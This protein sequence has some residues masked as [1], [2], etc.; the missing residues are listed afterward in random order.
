[1]EL[2]DSRLRKKIFRNALRQRIS[3]RGDILYI[4]K[5]FQLVGQL[6]FCHRIVVRINQKHHIAP[7][8]LLG[9][10]LIIRINLSSRSTAHGAVSVLEVVHLLSHIGRR[11]NDDHGRQNQVADAVH[12][13]A[14][15]GKVREEG[16]VFRLI[17]PFGKF[18]DH[19]RHEQYHGQKA[20]D[21][22]LCQNQA[23]IETDVEFHGNQGQ[24]TNYG[25]QAA[26]ENG[27]DGLFNRL[28][29]CFLLGKSGITPVHV[30]IQQENGIIHGG[31]QL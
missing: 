11:S 4:W 31:C 16:T 25:G 15:S 19:G 13:P 10:F 1:M 17:I 21:D 5:I 18:Q 29:D 8:K 3:H 6:L 22:T 30:G 28:D 2:A 27:V 23:H 12:A 14:Q 26:G 7:A 24:E 20:E 9:N